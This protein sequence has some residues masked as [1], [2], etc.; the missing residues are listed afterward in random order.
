MK[1]KCEGSPLPSCKWIAGRG[2]AKVRRAEPHPRTAHGLPIPDGTGV[3]VRYRSSRTVPELHPGA[4]A[5]PGAA[6]GLQGEFG[7]Q[8]DAPKSSNLFF[9]KEQ[10]LKRKQGCLRPLG[11]HFKS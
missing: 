5:H 7:G 1:S 10:A 9:D 11:E 3:P 4:A 8:D 6:I 2:G